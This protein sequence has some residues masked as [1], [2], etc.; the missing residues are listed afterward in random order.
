MLAQ[1]WEREADRSWTALGTSMAAFPGRFPRHGLNETA[2]R[3]DS[4]AARLGIAMASADAAGRPQPAAEEAKAFEALQ[5]PLVAWLDAQLG[6]PADRIAAPPDAVA[7][8][9]SGRNSDVAE[10]VALIRGGEAPVWEQDLDRLLAA[11]IPYLKGHMLLDRLLCASALEAQ[12]QGRVDFAL[13]AMEAAARASAS[14]RERPEIINRVVELNLQSAHAGVLRKLEGVPPRWYAR[15]AAGDPR[16]AM[17]VSLQTEAW[18]LSTM[19]NRSAAASESPTIPAR[20]A[21]VYEKPYAVLAAADYSR[22]MA[23]T[24]AALEA[25]EA[26]AFDPEALQ[27]ADERARHE[28]GVW[29]VSRIAMPS[30]AAFWTT[31]DRARFHVE[32][33]TKVIELKAARDASTDGSWPKRVPGIESS[34]CPG[35]RWTYVVSDDGRAVL[36]ASQSPSTPS[37]AVRFEGAPARKPR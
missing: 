32:L 9:L 18:V 26:C 24:A 16:K 30:V 35:N 6:D 12:R 27:A 2:R 22:A 10:L 8:F 13:E 23:R 1:R 19:L 17:L 3:L 15:A 37:P 14:L 5:P 34:V 36:S 31:A 25:R 33:T 21:A 7:A 11:P 28:I 4:A 29:N 20:V